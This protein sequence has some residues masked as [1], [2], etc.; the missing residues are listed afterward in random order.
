MIFRGW[1]K[2][3]LN[4]WPN[5]V[6]SVIFT[7]GCNFRC[8]FCHNFD[9]VL[10]QDKFP[11][12]T[13]KEILDYLKSNNDLLDGVMITGGEPLLGMENKDSAG[14]KNLIDF[15]QKI[16]EIGLLVGIETNGSFPRA[17]EFLIE[18][19]AI[20]YIA[21]DIKAPLKQDKYDKL[22]GQKIDL[23]KIKKSVKLIIGSEINYEFRTTAVPN[24]LT[25]ED[26][27]EIIKDLKGAK[28]YYLQQF[29]SKNVLDKNLKESPYSNDWFEAIKEK[30][31]KDFKI[32]LRV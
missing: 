7:G 28:N 31:K 26:I 21:M 16:K 2:V 32:N 30:I 23:K 14:L 13:E 8:P 18:K 11:V 9:L 5:K 1:Q 20:D 24:L 3:S 17:L 12:I 27:L 4:E 29:N 6:C 22:S 19:K 15:I 10:N 25:S